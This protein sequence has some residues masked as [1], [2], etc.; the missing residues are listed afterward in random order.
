MQS[1]LINYIEGNIADAQADWIIRTNLI[2]ETSN[3][4]NQGI[5]IT[6]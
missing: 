6:I 4:I 3:G 2:R 1:G 5:N